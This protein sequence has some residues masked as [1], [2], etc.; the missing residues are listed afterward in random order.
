MVKHI[1]YSFVTRQ[2]DIACHQPS[3]VSNLIE[4]YWKDD[5]REL[6]LS[7]RNEDNMG[8]QL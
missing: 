8:V 6:G 2:M 4:Q 3:F 1:P 7:T 5:T